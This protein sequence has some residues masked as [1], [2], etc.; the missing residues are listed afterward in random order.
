MTLGE[1]AEDVNADMVFAEAQQSSFFAKGKFQS[2]TVLARA[3]QKPDPEVSRR[4][5]VK[6]EGAW[7]KAR[8]IDA[9]RGRFRV[10]YYGWEDADD[11]WVLPN[12]IGNMSRLEYGVGTM[13]E[14]NWKGQWYSAEVLKIDRGANLVHYVGYDDGWDEWVSSR[15]IRKP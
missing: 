7:Y 8:I 6:S 10:H 9:R 14:V 2:D 3:P 12:Q 5:E 1:L 11:E 4:V 13:M 15:R